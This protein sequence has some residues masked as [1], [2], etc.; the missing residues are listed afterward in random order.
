QKSTSPPWSCDLTP[1]D[2]FLWLSIKNSIVSAPVVDMDDLRQRITNKFEEINNSPWMLENVIDSI[3][4]SV[5]LCMHEG[6][7]H[8]THL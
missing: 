2:F 7:G 5:R 6:S 4:R 1:C 8:I 3:E